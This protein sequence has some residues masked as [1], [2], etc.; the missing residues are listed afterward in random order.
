MVAQQLV[1]QRLLLEE[2]AD[3]YVALAMQEAIWD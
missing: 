3:R 2:D 1:E